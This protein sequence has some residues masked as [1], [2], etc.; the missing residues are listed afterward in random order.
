MN[1][2][3]EKITAIYCRLAH[4]QSETDATIT[5]KQMKC[6]SCYA[7]EH[8]LKNPRFF[9]DWGFSGITENRPAYQRM[10]SEIKHGNVTDLV[11]M[12]ISRFCRGF[13][14]QHTLIETVLLPHK[15]TLHSVQDSRILTPNELNCENELFKSLSLKGGQA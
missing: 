7:G 4:Y 6:L 10:L 9:C 12:N 2:Q 14:E 8:S 1:R 15:V 3:S 5:H 11:V 13:A